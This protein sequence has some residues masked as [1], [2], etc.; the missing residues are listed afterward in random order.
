MLSPGLCCPSRRLPGW[1]LRSARWD[2]HWG[3]VVVELCLLGSLASCVLLCGDAPPVTCQKD[4]S[5][6]IQ[7]QGDEAQFYFLLASPMKLCNC[8]GEQLVGLG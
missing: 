1:T 3:C 6:H 8:I 2:V 5:G 4:N 7:L